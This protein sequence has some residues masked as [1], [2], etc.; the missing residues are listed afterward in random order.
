MTKTM[1]RILT[2]VLAACMLLGGTLGASAASKDKDFGAVISISKMPKDATF[3]PGLSAPDLSGLELSFKLGGVEKILRYDDMYN[4]YDDIYDID[5]IDAFM[6]AMEE[7]EAESFSIWLN[8]PDNGPV[9]GKNTF[10]LE[11]SV[12]HG[13]ES[14]SK[15]GIPITLTG[16]NLLDKYD[17]ADI[18]AL[19]AGLPNWV[20][21]VKAYSSEIA[22]Y[23]FT[24]KA[25]GAYM[26]CSYF[27]DRPRIP[28]FGELLGSLSLFDLLG[29]ASLFRTRI[30]PMGKLFDE[31]GALVAEGD[32][33]MGLYPLNMDFRFTARLE[34]GK[35]YYFVPGY[36]GDEAPYLVTP[37]FVGI[38][39]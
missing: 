21:P 24:P 13:K 18:A 10:T 5:D 11:V 12:N 29:M 15:S 3:V 28:S 16:V 32:D 35:T 7:R 31:E 33:D 17:G 38:A 37:A 1:F 26:F 36:Y 2:A 27:S 9:I 19:K 22:L 8:E 23:S 25:S 30:D 6:R 14:Y 34:A 20:N 39:F 4:W